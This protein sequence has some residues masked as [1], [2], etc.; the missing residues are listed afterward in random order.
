VSIPKT[1]PLFT[2]GPKIPVACTVVR[3]PKV[4]NGCALG[5]LK[6]YAGFSVK[7][8]V[9]SISPTGKM[10]ASDLAGSS[11]NEENRRLQIVKRLTTLVVMPISDSLGLLRYI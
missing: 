7:L 6:L 2:K 8:P 9:N 3:V 4:P 10:V 5:A 11:A 1:S